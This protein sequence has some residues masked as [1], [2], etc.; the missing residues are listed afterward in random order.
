M[1]FR[2]RRISSKVR[3]VLVALCVWL[4]LIGFYGAR[5]HTVMHLHPQPIHRYS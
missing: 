1:C 2:S 4:E 3:T 5:C